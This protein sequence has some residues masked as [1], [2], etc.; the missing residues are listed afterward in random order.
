MTKVASAKENGAISVRV[1]GRPIPGLSQLLG[2][3]IWPVEFIAKKGRA[4]DIAQLS[5]VFPGHV[6]LRKRRKLFLKS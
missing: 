3:S 5:D 4:W 2:L 6:L 1:E